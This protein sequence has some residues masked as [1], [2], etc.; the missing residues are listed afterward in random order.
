MKFIT[1]VAGILFV[2]SVLSFASR[3]E[4]IR[5]S[6]AQRAAYELHTTKIHNVAQRNYFRRMEMIKVLMGNS[7]ELRSDIRR[8][9]VSHWSRFSGVG[10][11]D[12]N[13][14]MIIKRLV[15]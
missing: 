2:V 1:F 13:D 5:G 4:I 6:E 10:I 12:A 15:K 7:S 8:A 9:K 11:M 14:M 3:P